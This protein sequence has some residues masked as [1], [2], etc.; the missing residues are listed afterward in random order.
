MRLSP[1]SLV[2]LGFAAASVGCAWTGN[3]ATYRLWTLIPP[4]LF[5]QY[6]QAHAWHF[7]P[8][9]LLC[10]FPNAI[11]A[12][13]LALQGGAPMA[14]GLLW[15]CALL[16]LMP[17]VVTPLYFLPLQE[18]LSL[19]GPTPALVAQ[20]VNADVALRAAPA[21]LQL[22][23]LLWALISASSRERAVPQAAA[24]DAAPAR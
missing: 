23:M 8:V 12:L 6:Q 14:R 15:A 18:Q 16:A 19:A 2:A 22:G 10:G 4:E 1:L 21:T 3:V 5:P 20:L 24:P 7:V 17:W 11:F 9:A 13:L